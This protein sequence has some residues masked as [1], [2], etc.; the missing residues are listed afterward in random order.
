MYR[1]IDLANNLHLTK[2]QFY[3]LDDETFNILI[4]YYF[5]ACIPRNLNP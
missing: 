4:I 5:S 1:I 2:W 3:N